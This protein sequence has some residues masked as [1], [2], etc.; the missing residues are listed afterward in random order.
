MNE[1]TLTPGQLALTFAIW[2]ALCFALGWLVAGLLHRIWPG[3]G[4]SQ[5]SGSDPVHEAARQIVAASEDLSIDWLDD[6]PGMCDDEWHIHRHNGGHCPECYST[7]WA[8]N[9]ESPG[10][11]TVASHAAIALLRRA[12]AEVDQEQ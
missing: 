1:I 9:G 3:L 4:R 10:E 11:D 2:L 5:E 12:L 6:Y 8:L 7:W